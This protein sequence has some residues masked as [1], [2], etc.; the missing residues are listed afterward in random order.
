MQTQS[1][2]QVHPLAQRAHGAMAD[3]RVHA[4][5]QCPAT[6]AYLVVALLAI[7]ALFAL[8]RSHHQGMMLRQSVMF[9]VLCVGLLVYL[10]LLLFHQDVRSAVLVLFVTIVG[11]N[12]VIPTVWPQP[13]PEGRFYDGHPMQ[14]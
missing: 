7:Y 8:V 10:R 1:N 13:D 12:V 2:H 14:L 3:G 9:T 4:A 6:M 11:T 5:V